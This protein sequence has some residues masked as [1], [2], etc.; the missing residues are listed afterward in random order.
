MDIHEHLKSNLNSDEVFAIAK[1]LHDNY[2]PFL[3]DCQVWD[4]LQNIIPDSL[5]THL[6]LPHKKTVIGHKIINDI[7]MNV[8]FGERKIKYHLSLRHMN[9]EDEVSVFE[10]N[11]G[12]SRL[13]YARINGHSYAYEIKTELDSLE[14][15]EKQI[16]DYSQVF[17]YIHVVCHPDHYHKVANMT[18]EY[19]GIITYNTEKD[20]LPFSFRRKRVANPYVNPIVQIASLTAKELGKILKDEGFEQHHPIERENKEELILSKIS[21]KKINHHFKETVKRRFQKRWEFICKNV[22]KIEPIDLQPFFKST[23]DPYWVYYKNS[24]MV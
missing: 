24:S 16:S 15:L 6:L 21:S 20:D 8:Y 10:F 19:C 11:V 17:E 1:A 14:K 22:D 3:L 13:D 5:F 2:Q 7:V 12:S 23:A 4:L 9:N 18:P